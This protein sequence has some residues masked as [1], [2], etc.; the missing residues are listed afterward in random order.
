MSRPRLLIATRSADKLRE[1]RELFDA[2]GL[3]LEP[4]DLIEAGVAPAPEEDDLEHFATF[5]ENAL[6]K[7]RY[8]AER[9]GLPTLADDS[10][11]WVD[12]LG[13]AP[14]VHSKRFSG[15]ADL[16]GAALDAAN[17]Q[18]LLERLHGVPAPE[19]TARYRCA[20]ALARPGGKE[21]VFEGACEGLILEAPRGSGGFG[22]DPLFYLP[23]KGATFGELRPEEKNRLSHRARA[24]EAAAGRLRS[25][26]VTQSGRA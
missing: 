4:I 24:V 23:S 7:A 3:E 10:G 5:E 9:T 22:Y 2:L 25:G 19:R 26:F 15:R 20:V 11:L 1:I 18:L 8:F 16:S 21:L 14:G 12:A 6:A 17:N 13:G